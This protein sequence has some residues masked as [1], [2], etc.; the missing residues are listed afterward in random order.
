MSFAILRANPG[1]ELLLIF[2]CIRCSTAR[3]FTSIQ[4]KKHNIFP[5]AYSTIPLLHYSSKGLD[6][7]FDIRGYETIFSDMLGQGGTRDSG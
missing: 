7:I 3:S 5:Y 4:E 6:I 2:I 1:K